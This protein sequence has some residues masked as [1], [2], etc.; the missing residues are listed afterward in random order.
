MCAA[1]IKTVCRHWVLLIDAFMMT[2]FSVCL[3]CTD[4]CT[5]FNQYE[6]ARYYFTDISSFIL[7][8]GFSLCRASCRPLLHLYGNNNLHKKKAIFSESHFTWTQS[9][10]LLPCCWPSIVWALILTRLTS[11][12]S[13]DTG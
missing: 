5:L 3:L 8:I 10:T 6:I 7:N 4:S 11:E 13:S 12:E 2:L 9:S 1:I